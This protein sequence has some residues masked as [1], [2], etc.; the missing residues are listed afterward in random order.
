MHAVTD[1]EFAQR[2]SHYTDQAKNQ[3]VVVTS[4]GV[5]DVYL[6]SP[7]EFQRYQELKR[8]EREA[9]KLKELP[10]DIVRA[11]A[12]A[13]IAPECEAFNSEAPP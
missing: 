13:P 4:N 1:I 2:P 3:P 10:E 7:A 9:F 12:S 6:L 8:R 5:P 11:I